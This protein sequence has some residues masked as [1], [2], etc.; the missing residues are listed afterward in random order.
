MLLT[1]LLLGLQ[2]A[3][4]VALKRFEVV[5]VD[6]PAM[7]RLPSSLRAIFADPTP[8]AEPVANLDEA[9]ARVGFAP[10]LPKSADKPEFGVMDSVNGRAAVSIAELK[11]ALGSS[12]V[13]D[14]SIP[15]EWDG[16]EITIR[17]DA[18]ILAD[19]GSFL[20]MQAPPLTLGVPQGFALDRFMEIIFRILGI[21]AKDA[22][23]LRERFAANAAAF[24]PI[25]ARYEMDIRDVHLDSGSGVLLQNA[26]KI[27]ELA[28]AWSTADRSYF[29]T[30]QLTEQQVIEIANSIQ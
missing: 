7:E 10:R 21:N 5:R 9:A 15:G 28:L 26:D 18:G 1:A 12:Q 4:P 30:G 23:A 14:V 13:S 6:E 17:Q 29:I 22:S 16:V 8:G 11:T 2:L 19:Y 25:G 20:I 3:Q 24:L 27:G